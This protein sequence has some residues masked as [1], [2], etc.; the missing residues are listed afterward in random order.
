M[1]NTVTFKWNSGKVAGIRRE[2]ARGMLRMGADIASRARFNAPYLTGALRN[3]IRVTADKQDTVY[4]LAGGQVSDK[5]G[6]RGK[7]I[8]YA[9]MREFVN[10]AHPGTTHY[11]QRAFDSVTKGNIRQYFGGIK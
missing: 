7:R 6:K 8:D 2:V 4:V 11:M 3:S 10:K 1:T 9:L 5:R